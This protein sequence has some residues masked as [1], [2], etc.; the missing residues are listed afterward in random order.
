MSNNRKYSPLGSER[1]KSNQYSLTRSESTS[2]CSVKVASDFHIYRV[3]WLPIGI[4]NYIDDELIREKFPPIRGFVDLGKFSGN[5]IWRSESNVAPFDKPVLS[6]FRLSISR[7]STS[8]PPPFKNKN[9]TH[10]MIVSHQ[11]I[12]G[13]RISLCSYE[14]ISQLFWRLVCIS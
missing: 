12:A 10:L 1:R 14:I 6:L 2:N 11:I 13:G 8:I 4:R 3:F 5:N 9:S 7:L